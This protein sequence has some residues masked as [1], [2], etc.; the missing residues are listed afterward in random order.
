M[1]KCAMPL[2]VGLPDFGHFVRT[3]ALTF[4]NLGQMAKTPGRPRVGRKV[5]DSGYFKR[6]L[7][8]YGK[9]K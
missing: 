8:S 5:P 1:L 3:T 4:G 6:L 2:C 9:K 7:D